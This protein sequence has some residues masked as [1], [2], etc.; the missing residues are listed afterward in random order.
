MLLPIHCKNVCPR[1]FHGLHQTNARYN[2][3]SI[4]ELGANVYGTIGHCWKNLTDN[5][6]DWL[7]LVL[8]LMMMVNTRH[9]SEYGVRN[10]IPQKV[11]ISNHVYPIFCG[12]YLMVGRFNTQILHKL[13]STAKVTSHYVELKQ[14]WSVGIYQSYGKLI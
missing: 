7:A 8:S 10:Y 9:A 2:D 3:V 12:I 6:Q 11:E 4:E 14:V 5:L 1:F 13:R